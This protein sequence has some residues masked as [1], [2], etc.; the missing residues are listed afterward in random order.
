LFYCLLGDSKTDVQNDLA[1]SV[2]SYSVVAAPEWTALFNRT[3][4]WFESD[5]IFAIPLSGV[6]SKASDSWE[7]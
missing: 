2:I 1:D 7:N 6:D 5:G 4:G 3:T